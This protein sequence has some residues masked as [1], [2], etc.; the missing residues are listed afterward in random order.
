M[1]RLTRIALVLVLALASAVTA[2]VA[3]AALGAA[4]LVAPDSGLAGPAEVIGYGL[5]AALVAAVVT[6]AAAPRLGTRR[7]STGLVLRYLDAEASR[8]GSDPQALPSPRTPVATGAEPGCGK[9]APD[10][11]QGED[12][13]CRE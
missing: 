8:A 5:L 12:P 9:M 2:F 13:A 1:G 6:L 10:P 7:L 11:T 3:G 4:F